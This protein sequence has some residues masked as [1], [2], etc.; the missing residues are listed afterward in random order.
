MARPWRDIMSYEEF[1]NLIQ[2][3]RFSKRFLRT[4][5]SEDSVFGEE[6]AKSLE[7]VAQLVKEYH[8]LP[9]RDEKKI[10]ERR[11]YLQ[12]IEQAAKAWFVACGVRPEALES[13][14]DR[15]GDE[16]KRPLDWVMRTLTR[17]SRRK[18][19]YLAQ[20]ASYLHNSKTPAELI[21]YVRSPQERVNGQIGLVSSVKMEE[22]DFVHRNGYEDGG[23]GKAFTAWCDDNTVKHIPFFLWLEN[24]EICTSSFK[25]GEMVCGTKMVEYLQGRDSTPSVNSKMRVLDFVG[26]YIYAIGLAYGSTVPQVCNTYMDGYHGG[27]SKSI[28]PTNGM[29]KG[30]AC[31]VWAPNDDV[32]IADHCPGKFHHSSFLSGGNVKCAGMI[33]IDLGKVTELSNH[34]GH[35]KPRPE[36]CWAFVTFLQKKN[37]VANDCYLKIASGGGTVYEGPISNYWKGGTVGGKEVREPSVSKVVLGRAR[38]Q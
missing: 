23:I 2:E 26:A 16:S 24:H 3:S 30:L 19:D 9:K 4:R 29:G 31:Y 34:S 1:Q 12:E 33:R 21:E 10:H 37:V 14:L 13:H 15:C 7:K 25:R 22:E 5:I 32:F 17:R 36:E 20:L 27:G 11:G 35:Y 6:A 38:P 8:E 28:N 18:R